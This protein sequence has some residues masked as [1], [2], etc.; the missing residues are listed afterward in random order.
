MAATLSMQAGPGLAA[1]GG[2]ALKAASQA[3]VLSGKYEVGV[4]LGEGLQGKVYMGKSLETG[5]I[6]ALK[7]MD[8]CVLQC[9]NSSSAPR[10]SLLHSGAARCHAAAAASLGY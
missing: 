4:K 3:R 1:P 6:V 8:R 2:V 7:C 5:D 10:W 9:S